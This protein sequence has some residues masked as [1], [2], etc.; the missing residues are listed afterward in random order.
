MRRA[1]IA[2]PAALALSFLA[3]APSLAH[4]DIYRYVDAKGVIHFSNIPRSG[5]KKL[6]YESAKTGRSVY[7]GYR[8]G[9]WSS[10]FYRKVTSAELKRRRA[11][12]EPLI[13]EAAA[14]QGLDPDLVK[15]VA[16]IESGFNSLARSPAGAMGIMQLMPGTADLVDVQNPYDAGQNIA[17]GC[18]YLKQMLTRF[19]GDVTLALAA[20]NAGPENVDKYGGIPPFQETRDYVKAVSYQ[21]RVYTAAS[22]SASATPAVAV[23]ATALAS[24]PA[25]STTAAATAVSTTPSI[26][27]IAKR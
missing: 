18:R 7:M 26:T 3:F 24:A 9:I 6:V 13:L 14:A 16:H 20:Y 1:Q 15:A 27:Q 5:S 21:H 19:K 8:T 17:G 2:R 25:A 10:D 4:A 23:P 22:L 12:Y 11:Q